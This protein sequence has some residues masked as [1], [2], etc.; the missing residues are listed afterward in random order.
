VMALT[1]ERVRERGRA[2]ALALGRFTRGT[3]IDS[4]AKSSNSSVADAGPVSPLI[5]P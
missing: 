3:P 2:G 4:L 1:E 5:I